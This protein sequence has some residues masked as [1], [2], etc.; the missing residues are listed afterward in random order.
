[1]RKSVAKAVARCNGNNGMASDVNEKIGTV[2]HPRAQNNKIH[3]EEHSDIASRYI[4]AVTPDGKKLG[5]ASGSRN[6]EH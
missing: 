6:G 1:M 2:R 3:V 5:G 4:R